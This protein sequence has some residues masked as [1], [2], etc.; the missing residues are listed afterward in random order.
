[1]S[2]TAN[3]Q[4]TFPVLCI[5]RA[6][7]NQTAEMVEEAINH[8][9]HGK[10]VKSVGSSTTTDKSGT[11]FNVFFIHPDQDFKANRCTEMLY[12]KIKTEGIAQIST[13]IGKFF[14]KVKLYVPH[15]K[16]QYLPPPP[17]AAA[18]VPAPA[19]NRPV[20][21]G[22]RIMTVEEVEEFE[23]WRREKAAAKAAAEKEAAEKAAAEAVR[24]MLG[25]RLY[26]L[27]VNQLA[28]EF[29]AFKHA[30]KITGMI[31]EMEPADVEVCIATPEILAARI[32][33]G[34]QVYREHLLREAGA[35]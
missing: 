23:M 7:L 33:E 15:L 24:Q 6:M 21:V 29:P 3:T 1:M 18:V 4:S 22:P 10:F 14:W 35:A 25:E 28:K 34:V 8:A 5:P 9:M 17:A 32:R 27:V 20:P 26:P 30:G 12:N 19:V 13:G 11:Q 31:L 16:A 2:A